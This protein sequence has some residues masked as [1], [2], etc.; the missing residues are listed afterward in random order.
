MTDV[1]FTTGHL[2]ILAAVLGPLLTAIAVLFRSLLAAKDDQIKASAAA[3]MVSLANTKELAVA[4]AESNKEL[5]EIRQDL[6]RLRRI[7]PE[8]PG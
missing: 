6:W 2:T 5:R 7:G 8:D 1:S 4:Q 3:L